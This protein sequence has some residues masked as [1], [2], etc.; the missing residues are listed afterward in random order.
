VTVRTDFFSN[1]KLGVFPH[2]VYL[3]CVA[4][5]SS[6]N[7]LKKF[8]FVAGTRCDFFFGKNRIF[9]CYLDEVQLQRVELPDIC[10]TKTATSVR[11][12]DVNW[13]VTSE[14]TDARRR[15]DSVSH[16][17]ASFTPLMRHAHICSYPVML[18]PTWTS[19]NYR[20]DECR[21][22]VIVCVEIVHQKCFVKCFKSQ[23]DSL[24]LLNFHLFV[25]F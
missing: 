1:Q 17:G 2:R 7:F 13:S 9:K 15:S 12:N 3:C 10:S 18:E 22:K 5:K 16:R 19:L 14:Q 8:I 24:T 6:S 11:L 23:L 25:V 21:V 20:L 4:R